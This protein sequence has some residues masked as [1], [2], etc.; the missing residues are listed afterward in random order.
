[1]AVAYAAEMEEL[2]VYASDDPVNSSDPSGLSSF[3]P[4]GLG[5]L[6][7]TPPAPWLPTGEVFPLA[8]ELGQ[9]TETYPW[10]QLLREI[11][12]N[13]GAPELGIG[14]ETYPEETCSVSVSPAEGEGKN[15][16]GSLVYE[17]SPK[18]AQPG[19]GVGTE[20]TNPEELLQQSVPVKATSTQRIAYDPTTGEIVVFRETNPG[21][22]H[23]YVVEYLDL[24]QDQRN[25]LYKAGLVNLRGKPMVP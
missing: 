5:Q 17:P 18:H 23:G 16:T 21:V 15:P 3:V 7:V 8:P 9:Q 12:G 4:S 13:P 19:P 6:L 14:T 10:S 11:L 22:Y 25:A 2:Y 24:A 1:M 20:P